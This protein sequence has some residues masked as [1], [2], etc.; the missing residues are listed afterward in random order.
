MASHTVPAQLPVGW[1]L[2]PCSSSPSEAWALQERE[3]Q[4]HGQSRADSQ[5]PAPGLGTALG[6]TRWS[7]LLIT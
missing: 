5:V 6:L 3:P 7:F 2:R 1:G 4:A